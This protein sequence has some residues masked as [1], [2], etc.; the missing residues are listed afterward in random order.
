MH[1]NVILNTSMYYVC[2]CTCTCL[3]YNCVHGEFLSILIVFETTILPSHICGIYCAYSVPKNSY[4]PVYMYLP[5]S[6]THTHTYTDVGSIQSGF[7]P[8]D[9]VVVP[10]SLAKLP[11][12]GKVP[13]QSL[14]LL[15]QGL[16]EEVQDQ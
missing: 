3:Y 9:G 8:V 2:T 10:A 4:T 16:T 14:W 1:K 11:A 12:G 5:P 15:Q 13:R 7:A 6:H